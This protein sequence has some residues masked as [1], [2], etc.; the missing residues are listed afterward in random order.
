MLLFLIPLLVYMLEF[1]SLP[2]ID[3]TSMK[4]DVSST[5]GRNNVSSV[6]VP[7]QHLNPISTTE[8]YEFWPAHTREEK[9]KKADKV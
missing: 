4:C 5:V 7:A 8:T 9:G 3:T 2:L 1:E 6:R